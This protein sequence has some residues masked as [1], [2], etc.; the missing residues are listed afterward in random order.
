MELV[1][2]SLPLLAKFLPR[3][4][5]IHSPFLLEMSHSPSLYFLL[6][7]TNTTIQ[8]VQYF[9]ILLFSFFIISYLIFKE[10]W[11]IN[12]YLI[13]YRTQKILWQLKSK[14]KLDVAWE[15]RMTRSV[16]TLTA[17]HWRWHSKR[18]W[19]ILTSARMPSSGRQVIV[20][21]AVR[22]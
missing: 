6:P 21:N 4:F 11:T 20:F 12:I 2:F 1:D 10:I 14:L 8:K 18:S 5:A 19:R 13:E 17:F 16:F 7:K 15:A 22:I 9:I 3:A